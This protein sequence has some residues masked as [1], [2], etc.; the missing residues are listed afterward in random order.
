MKPKYLNLIVAAVILITAG[1]RVPSK[2]VLSA[3][4]SSLDFVAAGEIKTF[5]VT[6]NVY[7]T[8]T[9]QHKYAWIEVSP[10]AGNGSAKV[11]VKVG[12]NTTTDKRDG[13][14]TITA[15]D[16][17]ALTLGFRQEAPTP[18]NIKAIGG[19]TAPVV[20]VAP[21]TTITETE[22]YSG[23]ISWTPADAA[24]RNGTVY[25]AA[26]TLMPK[27]GFTLAGVTANFFT[28]A[29]A[30]SVTNAANSGVITAEFPVTGAAT[31]NIAAIGG[32]TAPVAGA[33]P[34]TIVAET[35]QYTGTV[36]WTPAVA[37]F[38]N[39]TV[40]TAIITLTSKTGYTFA[41][42]PVNFFGVE[43]ATSA[44]NEANS[45][46]ITAVFPATDAATETVNIAAILGVTA[47]VAGATPATIVTETGQYTGTVAWTP[48]DAPFEYATVY[49]ATITLMPKTGYTFTGVTANF[50]SV[51]GVTSVN[52]AAN[53]NVITAVFP[54]TTPYL[55]GT[56]TINGSATFDQQLNVVGT[57]MLTS[58][59]AGTTPE[60]FAYQ[61]KRNGADIPGAT[62]STYRLVAADIGQTISV[63]VTAS[64]CTGSVTAS[65]D[66]V[67][68]AT[69]AA[70]TNAPTML[71]RTEN[72][73][74]LNTV[75]GVDYRRSGGDWQPSPTFTSL[76]A[77][78]E[79]FFSLRM[80]ETDTYAASEGGPSAN[81]STTPPADGSPGNPFI[82]KDE[83]TLR[84]V[85]SGIDGWTLG[86]N[87]LQI[88]NIKL[89]QEWTPIADGSSYFNGVYDGGGF[90]IINL[91]ISG[92][93]DNKGMFKYINPGGVVRNIALINVNIT[94]NATNQMIGGITGYN[95]SA[96]I[97]NC[98]VTGKINGGSYAGG[99][100]GY[101]SNNGVIRNCYTT[102]D[103][104]GDGTRIGGIA[105]FLSGSPT[106]RPQVTN[107]YATGIVSGTDFLGGIVG[108]NNTDRGIVDRCVALNPY[109]LATD[110]TTVG[111]ITS[112]KVGES[113]EN[114]SYTMLIV[115]DERIYPTSDRY[116]IHGA[117][118]PDPA[119]IN[120]IYN[121]S[122][123]TGT[124]EFSDTKWVIV[125][126]SLPT[127]K[128]ASGGKFEDRQNPEIRNDM[129]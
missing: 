82:V 104:K 1:C 47:P 16:V 35:A 32:V 26:I 24:F 86:M 74:T 58:T 66:P 70:P 14:I 68:K 84:K 117:S 43:G 72:S 114:F 111:R 33:T 107:C 45:N 79:Y 38:G 18:V 98:Y 69:Q 20:N 29:G 106:V 17:P 102:C 93:S 59:P 126:N 100:A 55:T 99:V 118:V 42:V 123:W 34:A 116:S 95:N 51:E 124:P 80:Q 36:A 65:T 52:N 96:V 40:Y 122:W 21:V 46:V 78:T 101:N 27:A 83:E 63:T 2:P 128:T 50:F 125:T 75:I 61:W 91:T 39:G 10:D 112:G 31:V 113:S 49:T 60:G 19:V 12:A 77:N 8:I 92:N 23:T 5:E 90:S 64:N 121:V 110:G 48:D 119:Y 9:G 127:L 3:S 56:I 120:G 53:S 71:S 30:A 103:I 25:T 85:G 11:T 129:P 76:A 37:S 105:G 89:E 81:F 44:T 6:S 67:T 7:W 28:V 62:S 88:A 57:N 94:S 54:T 4:P 108:L 15:T 13:E 109:I 41:G 115:N 87:Y 97:E 73:I 22:Q